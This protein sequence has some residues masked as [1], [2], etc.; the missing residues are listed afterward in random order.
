M[1][2]ALTEKHTASLTERLYPAQSPSRLGIPKELSQTRDAHWGFELHHPP[3]GLQTLYQ[4]LYPT[5][6]APP[7]LYQ[8]LHYSLHQ[9][10]TPTLWAFLVQSLGYNCNLELALSSAEP[11]SSSVNRDHSR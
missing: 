1:V 11:V 2:S 4:D 8:S 3:E 5:L 6:P 9:L 7:L 10:L